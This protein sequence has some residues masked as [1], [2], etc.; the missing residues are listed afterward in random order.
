MLDRLC[1]EE[2]PANGSTPASLTYCGWTHNK[3]KGRDYDPALAFY[4]CD[5]V[6]IEGPGEIN[7]NGYRWWWTELLGAVPYKRPYLVYFGGATF[8]ARLL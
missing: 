8:F 6:A 7:G 2:T 5:D 3:S 1:R 4:G